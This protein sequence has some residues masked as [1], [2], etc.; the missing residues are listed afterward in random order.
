MPAKLIERKRIESIEEYLETYRLDMDIDPSYNYSEVED[1]FDIQQ[2][3]NKVFR[4]LHEEGQ[5]TARTTLC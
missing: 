5:D 1:K 3:L 4:L 2:F